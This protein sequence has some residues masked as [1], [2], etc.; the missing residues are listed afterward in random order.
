MGCD[1]QVHTNYFVEDAQEAFNFF[2]LARVYISRIPLA[3][4][5]YRGV[6]TMTHFYRDTLLRLL[7]VLVKLLSTVLFPSIGPG[8]YESYCAL[9]VNEGKMV[10]KNV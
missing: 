4:T 3:I 5:R 10:R 8:L 6:R 9:K 7:A 2:R 1:S